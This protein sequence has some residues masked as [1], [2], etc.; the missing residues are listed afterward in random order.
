MILGIDTSCYTTSV[1]LV[2]VDGRLLAEGRRPL[3]VAQGELGLRQS[4]GLFS[5]VKQL[6]QV[7][8]EVM[9]QARPEWG[10]VQAVSVSSRPRPVEGSYMPCFLSGMAAAETASLAALCSSLISIFPAAPGSCSLLS[11]WRMP[12]AFRWS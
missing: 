2:D 1:A 5:H 10:P 12:P 11:R 8:E 4:E 9:A 6:P 7:M 3:S